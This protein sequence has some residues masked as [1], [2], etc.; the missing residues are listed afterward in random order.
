MSSLGLF[1]AA[2]AVSRFGDPI[3][4]IALTI[5][6]YRQTQ[7]ALYTALAVVI[8]TLPTAAFGFVGG[9]IADALGP[10]RAMVMCD[11]ARACLIAVV[12]ILLETGAPLVAVYGCVLLAGVFGAIFNPARIAIIPQL[13]PPERW[14]E[15]N[16]RI[17]ATDRTVEILGA[18]AAG[19]LVAWFGAGAFYID[20]LSFA[21]SALMILRIRIAPPPPAGISV[22]SILRDTGAG[23]R[24]LVDSSVLRANTIFSLAA[25]L[26]LPVVNGLTPVLLIRRFANGNADLG[27]TLFGAAEASWAAGAIIAGMT[28]PDYLERG[29]KGRLLIGGFA[30]FG[31]LLILLGFAPSL[32]PALVLFFCLGAANIVFLVPN[33]TISQEAT[34]PELR[35]RVAGARLALLNI[36]WLPMFAISGALADY[37][38]AGVL[39]AIAGAMTLTTAVI[40][41]FAPTVRDVD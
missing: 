32:L 26:A 9:A 13:V 16:A 17:G 37:V 28:L 5:V 36:T 27:A 22:V 38:D 34:P 15:A 33:I 31:V 25:Q 21:V 6:T 29:G 4:L 24:V 30:T 19:F 39:I 14:G 41:A 18:L 8:A 7:S 10:R 2:Q 12:P 40:G 20:A 23:L 3:T 11:V 1:W 35:A